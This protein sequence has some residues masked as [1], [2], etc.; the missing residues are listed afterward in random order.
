VLGLRLKTLSFQGKCYRY[1]LDN[2]F[3]ERW[4]QY[5]NIYITRELNSY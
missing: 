1:Q 3:G 5:E 2:K 4:S